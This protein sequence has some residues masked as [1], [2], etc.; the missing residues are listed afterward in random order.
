MEGTVE[1]EILQD[2][3]NALKEKLNVSGLIGKELLNRLEL[4]QKENDALRDDVWR[5]ENEKA[6]DEHTIDKLNGEIRKLQQDNLDLSDVEFQ[7]NDETDEYSAYS[8]LNS[9]KSILK[10]GHSAIHP[11]PSCVSETETLQN[12][13]DEANL[14]N[15]LLNEKLQDTIIERDAAR[16]QLELLRIELD[17]LRNSY[18]NDVIHLMDIRNEDKTALDS[19]PL[20]T[21]QEQATGSERTNIESPEPT[22]SYHQHTNVAPQLSPKSP[23]LSHK[24]PV[25]SDDEFDVPGDHKSLLNQ[26]E[27][28]KEKLQS[29]Q[30]QLQKMEQ[31]NIN[32]KVT[33]TRHSLLSFIPLTP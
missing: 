3:I 14:S 18:H 22:S 8:K 21:D 30:F 28:L 20:S 5:L 16:R 6:Y 11:S 32:L 2:E 17:S 31:S 4:V 25:Q 12:D 29:T 26:I 19:S 10:S 24:T 33:S 27:A 15:S 7:E 1:T 9:S 13:L 23:P